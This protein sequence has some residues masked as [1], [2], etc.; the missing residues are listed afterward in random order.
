MLML[1]LVV[2]VMM[3]PILMLIL[4]MMLPYHTAPRTIPRSG[5]EGGA[6]KADGVMALVW[7]R[8]VE[9]VREGE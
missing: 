6:G 3:M 5:S 4:M 2:M 9:R 8:W 1:L 7:G